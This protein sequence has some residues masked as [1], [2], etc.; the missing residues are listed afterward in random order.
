MQHKWYVI[1]N[2]TSG[3]GTSKKKWSSIFTELKLQEFDF[4]FVFTEYAKHSIS[5]IQ[6]A[7]QNGYEK[8]ICV[9]G[10]GTLHNII[11]GILQLNPSNLLDLK[12][13]IIPVGT[14]NDWIK[15]YNIS[16]NIKEAISIIKK[17]NTVIQDIGK[18]ELANNTNEIYFTNLAG[19]GFD[20]YV[21]NN[22]SKFK[23]LGF[24]AY[25][26]SALTSLTSFKKPT[27]E[28]QFN[29]IILKEKT[30]LLLIGICNYSGGGMKL[31]KASNP[32]SGLFDITHVN[33]ITLFTVL[34]NLK[35][36]FNGNI[37]NHKV[38]KNYKSTSIIIKVTDLKHA[39]I[40]ADG[41][42]IGL[43]DFKVTL[44]PNKLHFIIPKNI[45]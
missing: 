35:G 3:N 10:D 15:T 2:P 17:E 29:N 24:L 37:T 19:I 34:S 39:F 28:I 18:L 41:E 21:V 31:T 40:Q 36:L 23:K 44:L 26:T 32:N 16:K 4:D 12:V 7:I 1:I 33:R 13:G 43:G 25:I 6:T 11:N 5:L 14:G 9:G 8:F 22:V 30:L 38:V 45:N 42:L 27:L 20:G